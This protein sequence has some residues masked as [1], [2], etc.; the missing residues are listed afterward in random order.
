MLL[1]PPDWITLNPSG[2]LSTSTSHEYSSAAESW[3]SPVFRQ[4]GHQASQPNYHGPSSNMLPAASVFQP[5][6]LPQPNWPTTRLGT[7]LFRPCLHGSGDR[8]GISPWLFACREA[9]DAG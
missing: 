7:C 3:A 9:A 8:A 6:S 1:T 4:L 5:G 2:T